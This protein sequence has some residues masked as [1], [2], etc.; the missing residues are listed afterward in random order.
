ML[1]TMLFISVYIGDYLVLTDELDVTRPSDFNCTNSTKDECHK[2]HPGS[3]ANQSMCILYL[4]LLLGCCLNS[5]CT[6]CFI[7]SSYA[8]IYVKVS[9]PSV[10]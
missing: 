1:T 3:F 2:C 6:F 10:L 9:L 4:L 5:I 8:V 7:K